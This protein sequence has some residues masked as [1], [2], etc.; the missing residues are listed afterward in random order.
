[1]GKE[2]TEEAAKKTVEKSIT[3]VAKGVFQQFKNLFASGIAMQ[4]AIIDAVTAGA[5]FAVK[6]FILKLFKKAKKYIRG[7][8][9]LAITYFGQYIR[10]ALQKYFRVFLGYDERL[11]P[12]TQKQ[13]YRVDRTTMDNEAG[14]ESTIMSE[15]E[16]ANIEVGDRTEDGE[17]ILA[18]VPVLRNEKGEYVPGTIDEAL[19]EQDAQFMKTWRNYAYFAIA[20]D[21]FV[22]VG[23][24]RDTAL[25]LSALTGSWM[26]GA[27]FEMSLIRAV[28]SFALQQASGQFKNP[29]H[30]ALVMMGLGDLLNYMMVDKNKIKAERLTTAADVQREIDTLAKQ[31]KAMSGEEI[32]ELW[33]D[34]YAGKLP[35]SRDIGKKDLDL[36]DA[37]AVV[38]VNNA[39]IDMMTF[40]RA[41]YGGLEDEGAGP[42]FRLKWIKGNDVFFLNR[43]AE[44]V[45]DVYDY[46]VA[47]AMMG[48]FISAYH[49]QTVNDFYNAIS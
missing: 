32:S 34:F 7:L 33:D 1:M 46:G 38:S 25:A 2:A 31:G 41:Q 17:L 40:G 42:S 24:K 5:M 11:G 12:T 45:S 23:F 19:K 21:I 30:G 16:A 15:E 28:I 36:F 13:M 43:Y 26:T 29:T 4:G 9:D 39:N 48:Q 22:A 27:T 3:D 8:L 20:Q 14:V 37:F 10:H 18:K 6:E 35:L 47:D 44:Y 49:N